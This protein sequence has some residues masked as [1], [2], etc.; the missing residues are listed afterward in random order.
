[1]R[2]VYTSAYLLSLTTKFSARRKVGMLDVGKAFDLIVGTSTGGI[3]ACLLA[4]G[5][6]LEEILKIYSECGHKIFPKKMPSSL[7]DLICQLISRR[8]HLSNGEK[9]LKQILSEKF[10]DMTMKEVYEKRSIALAIPAIEMSRHQSWVF[11]TPHLNGHRDD[12]FKLVDVCLATSAAP[13]YRSL[14]RIENPDSPGHHYVFADGGLWAN[15]PVLVGLTEALKM[16]I[17][18]SQIEIFSLGTGPRPPGDSLD[19]KQMNRGL[20]EWK[21]GGEAAVLAL[22]SQEFAFDNM[23][24][25]IIQ[26]VNRDCKIFRF[27]CGN[28]SA[29]AMKYLDIDETSE[30]GIDVLIEQAHADALLTLSSCD[31]ENDREGQYF[32][33]LLS[34]IPEMN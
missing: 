3:I 7:T 34:S 19:S 4:A 2:G 11:K 10:D 26:H 25:M 33:E 28:F 18:G 13:L 21:L 24:R 30:R 22:D 16:T 5:V 23:A 12:Q 1:M 20:W 14:A 9:A 8:K 15:N 29:Q 32:A 6:P 31:N 27:P 17:P